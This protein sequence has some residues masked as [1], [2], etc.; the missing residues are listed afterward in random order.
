MVMRFEA[1]RAANANSFTALKHVFD[2]QGIIL[3]DPQGDPC[4]APVQPSKT[5]Y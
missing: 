5:L 2:R 1:R 4:P 3:I